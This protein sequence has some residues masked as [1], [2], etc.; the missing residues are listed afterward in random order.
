ME[1]LSVSRDL[2]VEDGASQPAS[3]VRK[4]SPGQ[5]KQVP[6]AVLS[7]WCSLGIQPTTTITIFERRG[8]E[9]LP[10]YFLGQLKKKALN[11]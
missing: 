10:T 7:T 5:P 4:P 3:P 9:A 11:R 8:K 6:G 1:V 2:Y